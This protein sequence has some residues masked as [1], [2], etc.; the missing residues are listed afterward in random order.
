MASINAPYLLE[1]EMH[2][3]AITSNRSKASLYVDH[4]TNK[5]SS[6]VCLSDCKCLCAVVLGPRAKRDQFPPT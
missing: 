3:L 6:Y 5:S 1:L 4:Y 2:T